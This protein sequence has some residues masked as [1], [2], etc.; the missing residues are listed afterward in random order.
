MSSDLVPVSDYRFRGTIPK[1]WRKSI[2]TRLYWLWHQRL[3]T[4]Q[5]IR[6]KT[7]DVLDRTAAELV[8]EAVYGDDLN[9]LLLLLQRL[10]GGAVRDTE[11]DQGEVLPV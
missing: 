7:D 1:E 5:Q 2:D 11:I 3:G 6:E 4:L 8:M 9:P 10:E